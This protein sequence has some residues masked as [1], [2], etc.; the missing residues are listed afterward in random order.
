MSKL[1][2]LISKNNDFTIAQ[3]AAMLDKSE[4]DIKSEIQDLK[5]K[6]IIKGY[7]A[8]VDWGKAIPPSLI[9]IIPMR[10]SSRRLLN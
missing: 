7:K 5:D 4:Q 3:L 8:V 2:E 10:N 9:G 6:G 1:L